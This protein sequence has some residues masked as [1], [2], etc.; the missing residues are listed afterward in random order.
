MDARIP[1]ACC[2]S[3]GRAATAGA[4]P[5]D[6]RFVAPPSGRSP[7]AFLLGGLLDDD[8]LALALVALM[9]FTSSS[10]KVSWYRSGFQSDDSESMS[11]SAIFN[12]LAAGLV[13]RV[14]TSSR[15]FAG[16]TSSANRMVDM[17]S[18]PIER[19]DRGQVLLVPHHDRTDAHLLG[20]VHGG[21]EQA[22]GPIV[23]V[24]RGPS[25]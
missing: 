23:G 24:V 9:I 3:A 16:I 10:V 18:A 25:Q 5:L 7:C 4:L 22:V 21:G 15:S 17:A 13:R 1:R 2:G 11:C 14:G 19:A 12:S 6:A 8:L 20:V